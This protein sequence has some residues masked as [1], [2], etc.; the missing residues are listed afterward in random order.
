MRSRSLATATGPPGLP[1]IGRGNCDLSR[2]PQ[3]DPRMSPAPARGVDHR[4]HERRGELVASYCSLL[5]RKDRLIEFQRELADEISRSEIKRDNPD[6][7]VYSWH[8]HLLRVIG[9]AL[10]RTLIPSHTIRT[11]GKHPGPDAGLASQ[12]DDLD[13]VFNVAEETMRAG[14]LPILCDLTNLLR[15]GDIV[16]VSPDDTVIIECKNSPVPVTMAASGRLHRQRVRGER[17]A[18][19]LRD[20]QAV[21]GDDGE[22]RVAVPIVEPEPRRDA[23]SR[24][25][26]R[27]VESDSFF[28]AECLNE[29]D[30]IALVG[31]GGNLEDAF[32]RLPDARSLGNPRMGIHM[33]SVRS[34][35]FYGGNPLLY[36]VAPSLMH[37]LLEGEVLML[38]LLDMETFAAS[39][40]TETGQVIEL[41]TNG[42]G[43][44]VEISLL[45]NG[46]EY[47]L[48][49]RFIEAV[50]TA[51]IA[52]ADMRESLIAFAE[53]VLATPE[54]SRLGQTSFDGN[55]K[56]TEGLIYPK[57]YLASGD[58]AMYTTAYKGP[59]GRPLLLARTSD[60]GG[61][62]PLE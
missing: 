5:D 49:P 47:G 12:K 36:P 53:N 44:R 43:A 25:Q 23:V 54:V 11:L 4:L 51:P 62:P 42:R 20:S 39:T 56:S 2:R 58:R 52:I 61:Q 26:S 31:E 59:D 30:W 7:Q 48:A 22:I 24:L 3:L 8:R 28:A 19:Y 29:G 17:A 55:E 60:V 33:D 21:N 32:S 1:T 38:R 6:F 34:P 9:D 35:T 15:V 46:Q 50:L 14:R 45:M 40:T 13:W 37:S 27:Y 18:D 10:A 16:A 57:A 41:A